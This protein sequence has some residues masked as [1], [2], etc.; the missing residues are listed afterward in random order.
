VSVDTK[1]GMSKQDD[2]DKR[3]YGMRSVAALVPKIARPVFQKRSPASAQLIA[4]W[5]Q[6]VGPELAEVSYAKRFAAGTLTI[7]CTGVVALEL[8]HRADMMIARINGG[9]GRALVDRI[10]F[11]QEQ[12][13]APPPVVK[14]SHRGVVMLQIADFPPGP[15]RDALEALGDIIREG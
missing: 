12:P 6:L 11:V 15:L 9:L 13:K 2:D 4:D 7:A 1:A 10:K 3:S 8:Q 5:D 14:R